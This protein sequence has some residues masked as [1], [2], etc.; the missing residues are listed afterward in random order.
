MK[1]YTRWYMC[2]IAEITINENTSK[3]SEILP[4]LR[5]NRLTP[6]DR[7]DGSRL[8]CTTY[9]KPNSDW[10]ICKVWALKK[11]H[12]LII[13]NEKIRYFTADF[14]S[15]AK[16]NLHILAQN[17]ITDKKIIISDEDNVDNLIDKVIQFHEPIGSISKTR[18][19][20]K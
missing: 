9:T 4:I 15:N 17:F 7:E 18:V 10:C 1:S 16:E 14:N 3:A 2:E 6:E 20:N 8:R 5:D 11:H 12:D 19:G 13:A